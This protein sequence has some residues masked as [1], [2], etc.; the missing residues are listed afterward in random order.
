MLLACLSAAVGGNDADDL[1]Q[2]FAVDM[3]PADIAV[4]VD[5]SG[6]MGTNYAIVRKQVVD[7]CS[8]LATGEN[9]H[10]TVFARVYAAP[11]ECDGA[12][13]ARRIDGH[14]PATPLPGE[15]TDIGLALHKAVEWLDRSDASSV[16]ALFFLTDGYHQP[17]PDSPFGTDPQ[18]DDDWRTLRQRGR[19]LCKNNTLRVYGFGLGQHTDIELLRQVFDPVAVELITGKAA[20][21]GDTLALVRK[22]LRAEGLRRAVAADLRE[23]RVEVSGPQA[24]EFMVRSVRDLAADGV[25]LPCTI[26]NQYR[27]LPVDVASIELRLPGA[28][29][30]GAGRLSVSI[31]DDVQRA[32]IQAGETRDFA[33]TATVESAPSSMHPGIREHRFPVQIVVEPVAAFPVAGAMQHLG[34]E[35]GAPRVVGG[36]VTAALVLRTGVAWWLIVGVVAAVVTLALVIWSAT[37]PS[38]LRGTVVVTLEAGG[39]VQQQ[40]VNLTRARSSRVEFRFPVAASDVAARGIDGAATQWVVESIGRGR[41]GRIRVTVGSR[42]VDFVRNKND[43]KRLGDAKV[44]YRPF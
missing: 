6:S 19:A 25:Q 37:R 24:N 1:Y 18:Q 35:A 38:K 16:Q 21:V 12:E 26:R 42:K 3:P 44:E 28:S 30:D 27:H 29:T 13:A 43:D 36:D 5:A 23:G 20:Q 39:G 7:F 2:L 34:L 32:T 11:L 33:I 8:S 15:G 10:I 31:A 4:L 40:E 22:R 14:L 9:V 41:R 17:P